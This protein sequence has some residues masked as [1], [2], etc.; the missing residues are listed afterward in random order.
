MSTL[1]G[2]VVFMLMLLT[3]SRV[4]DIYG[5][6]ANIYDIYKYLLHVLTA[7]HVSD[8]KALMELKSSYILPEYNLTFIF[9][10]HLA[11]ILM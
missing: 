2:T 4:P 5:W 7:D 6:F 10:I 11:N 9:S 3:L 8:L 1:R